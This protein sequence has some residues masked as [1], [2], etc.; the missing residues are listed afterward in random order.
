MPLSGLPVVGD[1]FTHASAAGVRVVLTSSQIGPTPRLAE[2][3]V[4]EWSKSAPRVY[5]QK[6]QLADRYESRVNFFPNDK[7]HTENA[8]SALFCTESFGE[9]S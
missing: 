9:L 2:A 3:R 8:V 4:L 6:P 7:S 1:V 5:T